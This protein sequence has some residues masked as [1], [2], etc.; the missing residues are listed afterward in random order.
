MWQKTLLHDDRGVLRVLCEKWRLHCNEQRAL[1]KISCETNDLSEC[2]ALARGQN[3]IETEKILIGN[4]AARY[5]IRLAAYGG[6]HHRSIDHK[7]NDHACGNTHSNAP[8]I[9]IE[10][11]VNAADGKTKI[12]NGKH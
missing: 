10:R 1:F 11:T 4:F 7:L 8:P 6:H 2:K 3:C 9:R 5:P 12:A